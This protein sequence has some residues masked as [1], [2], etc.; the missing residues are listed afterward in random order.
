MEISKREYVLWPQY[1]DCNLSRKYGRK[2]PKELCIPRPSIEDLL[3]ACR[4]LNLECEAEP[5]KLYPRSWY[6]SRGR[7][8]VIFAGPKTSLLKLIATKLRELHSRNTKST[9]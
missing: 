5:E 7:I 1:F 2:V 3:S 6:L 4:E 9:R 8:R